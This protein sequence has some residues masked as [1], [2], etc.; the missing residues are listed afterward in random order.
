MSVTR[1][2]DGC[3][4]V[5]DVSNVS[6]IPGWTGQAHWVGGTSVGGTGV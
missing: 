5:F 3:V 2:T 6:G 1:V 4:D